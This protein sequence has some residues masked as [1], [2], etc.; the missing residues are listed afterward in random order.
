VDTFYFYLKIALFPRTYH[1]ALCN[2]VPKRCP[3]CQIYKVKEFLISLNIENDKNSQ[4]T[5]K[6]LH[7]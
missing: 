1:F 4:Q 5:K 7:V 6:M 2:M 3:D